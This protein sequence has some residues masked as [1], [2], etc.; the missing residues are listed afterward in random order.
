MKRS[1]A[2]L[3]AVM[4]IAACARETEFLPQA[5]DEVE[6]ASV[7]S[8]ITQG[9]VVVKFTEEMAAALE[10]SDGALM[11]KSSALNDVI[12]EFG[13]VKYERVFDSDPRWEV[14]E[15]RE[16]LHLFYR[17]SFDSELAPATKAARD[18]AQM[19]G[20]LSADV[21]HRIKPMYTT[22]PNDPGFSNQWYLYNA[23]GCDLN[24]QKVWQMF[25]QGDPRVI[26]SVVDGGIRPDHPDLQDN[27]IP[28]GQGGS[29][30]FVTNSY[31]ITG[32]FHG[33]HVGGTI[34]AT[35]NNSVGVAGIAGGDHA[36]GSKGVRLLC[37]Q[38]FTDNSSAST[39]GFANAIKY[40]A[41]NGAV[42][43]QNSWG[44]DFDS[45]HDGVISD[46]EYQY[47]KN[48]KIDYYTKA[49]IDYFI[50]YAGCDNEGNQ[51]ADSPMKGGVFICAAGND[52]IDIGIPA[53]YPPSIAVGAYNAQGQKAAFSNYGD[54]VD[55]CAPGQFIYNTSCGTYKTYDYMSGTSMACPMVSGVAALIL[56]YRGGPGFTNEL[57]E[58]ALVKAADD[59]IP[60]SNIGPMV[61]AY[62]AI[63]YKLNIAP[64]PLEDYTAVSRA[65]NIDFTWT[66]Q[67]AKLG[68]PVQGA[69]ICASHNRASIAGLNPENPSEDV[70]VVRVATDNLE[71]GATATGTLEDL[72]FDSSY[73][74]TVVP[75]NT[76]AYSTIGI[77][78]EVPTGHNNPPVIT[79]R[80]EPSE[81]TLRASQTGKFVF[82]LADPDGHDFSVNIARANGCELW[83]RKED[84]TLVASVPAPK[85]DEVD[86][87]Y[88]TRI[89]L[90]DSYGAVTEYD[91]Q[92]YVLP[93]SAPVVGRKFKDIVACV[94]DK[95]VSLPLDGCFTDPDGDEIFYDIVSS[96]PSVVKG[97]VARGNLN[98]SFV[99]SG[100]ADLTVVARDG[101]GDKASQTVHVLLR[102]YGE[103]ISVYP[104]QVTDFVMVGTG[105]EPMDTH[106]EVIAQSGSVVYDL[107]TPTSA[108]EPAR[109][110]MSTTSPGR[111]HVKVAVGGETYIKTIVKL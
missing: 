27:L 84:G 12:R 77:I 73:Y 13:V 14:R 11:T 93:N 102:V 69:L 30:N 50:K 82:D 74:V 99:G 95:S 103:N 36:T 47:A 81:L 22:T 29:R 59:R 42:I 40:G 108:F 104:T 78:K 34:A 35:T 65:N 33:T 97:V 56:S 76:G 25:T 88:T 37:S 23:G 62:N 24:V 32:H 49:A 106:I 90:E 79:P 67:E 39:I 52:N 5:A 96:S 19:P 46:A 110:D 15:R 75:F 71:V 101:R 87:S 64:E 28:G 41:D 91:F 44:W 83:E 31:D 9:T 2:F 72:E 8:N 3:T 21:E 17:L 57:L 85:I 105:A 18:M 54:W 4:V 80:F 10:Q 6:Q 7:E 58:E 94:S 53:N 63:L 61:N 68:G 107:D 111:Y 60:A 86:R 48:S 20:V 43:S 16:G 26:V 98:V 45:N 109:I 51:L 70:A 55:I 38:V 66:V 92:Y 89:T 100:L 1:V